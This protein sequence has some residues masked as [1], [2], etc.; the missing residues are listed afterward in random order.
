MGM[1]V[2]LLLG[3]AGPDTPPSLERFA[4]EVAEVLG[5]ELVEVPSSRRTFF[6]QSEEFRAWLAFH[7]ESEEPSLSHP[8]VL[9][10]GAEMGAEVEV[11]TRVFQELADSGRF[12]VVLLLDHDCVRST[13]F[14]CEDW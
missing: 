3:M 1:D 6:G 12:R 11:G 7:P 9:E 5:V 2:D 13:H 14:P 10:L 4:P 8:F